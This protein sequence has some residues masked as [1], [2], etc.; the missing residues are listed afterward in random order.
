MWDA[1]GKPEYKEHAEKWFQVMKSR[2]KLKSDGTYQI[3]NYWQP[4]GP[5]DYIGSNTK[6]W[7]DVHPRGGYY[8]MDTRAIVAAYE[9]GLVFS[10]AE[11]DALIATAKSTWQPDAPHASP[12]PGMV[13]SAT[14]AGGAAKQVYVCF[15]NAKTSWPPP[16]GPGAVMG[17]VV[18][19]QWDAKASTGSIVI[20]PKDAPATKVTLTTNDDTHIFSLRTW[21]ALAPYDVEIQK[22]FEM[23][24]NPDNWNGFSIVPWY[25]ML[26]SE[27]FGR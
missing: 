18:S 19:C 27:Q 2:M 6:H 20:Q 12:A 17:T 26:Q 3:W 7:V 14:S 24:A 11:I 23:G 21:A 8:E 4:A 13:I 22:L 1:T 10:R 9:H 16:A 15:A 25:L 5:W